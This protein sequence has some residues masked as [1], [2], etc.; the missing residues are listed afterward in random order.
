MSMIFYTDKFVP[1]NAAGC[2]CAFLIFIR[3]DYKNDIGLLEHEK[4]HVLQW[5]RTFGL[6]SYLYLFSKSYRLKSE[7]EAYKKQ[8]EYSPNSAELFAKYI[9]TMYNI[10]ITQEEAKK[11]LLS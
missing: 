8:L 10:N 7:V 5:K 2:A 11:L 3:P 9:A 4:V 1:K 6:H